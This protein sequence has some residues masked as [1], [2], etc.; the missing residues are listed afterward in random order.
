MFYQK[1]VPPVPEHHTALVTHQRPSYKHSPYT[2]YI[3]NLNHKAPQRMGS[4]ERRQL[5]CNFYKMTGHTVQKC[6]KNHGY[7]SGHKFYKGRKV[8]AVATH[9][10]PNASNI[11]YN[12]VSQSEPYSYTVQ[13]FYT[14]TGAASSLTQEQ[15]NQFLQILNKYSADQ[16][17]CSVENVSAHG[18]LAGKRFCFFTTIENGTWIV[19]SGASDHIRPNHSLLQ[20]IKSI[21]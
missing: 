11:N 1:D 20:N 14:P 5:F 21:Q 6:Y 19:D 16:E 18:F 9:T 10:E 8:A 7:S 17:K 3:P 13:D 12:F 4:Q 2:C 15:Y